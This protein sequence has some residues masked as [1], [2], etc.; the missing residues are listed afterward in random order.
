M[1]KIV[2]TTA[3]VMAAIFGTNH[4]AY[5]QKGF[6]VSVKATPHLS[7][8][9][10]ADNK[11]IPSYESKATFGASFGVG[12]GYN[13]TN[14]LGI[15]LDVL[16]SLQGQKYEVAGIEAIQKLNYLKIP[17]MFTYNT[18]PASKIVFNAK[19]GPQIGIRTSSKITDGDHNDI[20]ADANSI[21]SSTDFGAV[22]GAGVRF[23]LTKK[24]SLDAGLRFDYAFTNAEDED[25]AFYKPG[26]AVTNNM[27]GGVE[28]GLRY[29]F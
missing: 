14:N 10:N 7:W 1:K 11:D 3:I 29:H 18:N 15:G 9:L 25:Y 26:R 2:T 17:L 21:Y 8:M 27:T 5:A 28:I 19:L 13:F 24:L 6:N 4:G 20:I 23:S 22:A 12:T 16:Y